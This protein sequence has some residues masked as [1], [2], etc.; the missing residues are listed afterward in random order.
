MA[1]VFSQD[2]P[3]SQYD[4]YKGIL[5][6]SYNHRLCKRGDIVKKPC[7]YSEKQQTSPAQREVRDAFKDSCNCWHLQKEENDW[8][9]PDPG[10]RPYSYWRN[11]ALKSRLYPYQYYMHRTISL[12]YKELTVPWCVLGAVGDASIANIYPDENMGEL[13][14]LWAESYYFGEVYRF[15]ISRGPEDQGKPYLNIYCLGRWFAYPEAGWLQ[16]WSTVPDS[17]DEMT[18]TWNN[19]PSQDA[20]LDSKQLPHLNQYYKFSVGAANS[21][22]FRLIEEYNPYVEDIGACTFASREHSISGY[23]PYFSTD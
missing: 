15:L 22:L 2:I 20:L 8:T 9:P 6:P 17:F 7:R 1:K 5:T 14:F 4:Y 10:P 13:S 3:C 19:A 11:L 23:R 18:V 21:I 12:F 16:A